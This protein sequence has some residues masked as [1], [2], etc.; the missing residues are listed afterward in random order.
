MTA[1]PWEAAPRE[2]TRAE[3][4]AALVGVNFDEDR[5]IYTI[6]KRRLLGVTSILKHAG[7]YDFSHVDPIYRDRGRDAHLAVHMAMEHDLDRSHLDDVADLGAMD[8]RPYV[9][10]AEKFIRE[11][12]VEILN[13]EAV[14]VAEKLGFAGKVDVF[15]HIRRGKLLSIIDWKLGELIDAYGVQ[16]AAYKLAWWEMTAKAGAP[17]LVAK[18]YG[19]RLLRDGTYK[20]REY[21][22]RQDEQRFLNA[23]GVVQT[24]M[25][26][27]TLKP[28]DMWPEPVAVEPF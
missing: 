9:V 25:E 16:L 5:H 13:P 12:D 10:A 23:L 11:H 2:P 15:G 27:G 18:R 3:K 24:R 7:Y 1:R 26:F 6:G 8:L 17:E 20:V 22:D 4:H 19:V 14:V 28:A 21:K